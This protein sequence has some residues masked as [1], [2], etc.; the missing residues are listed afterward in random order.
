MPHLDRPALQHTNST[1]NK[2]NKGKK[3]LQ[4]PPVPVHAL[5]PRAKFSPSQPTK[6]TALDTS[7]IAFTAAPFVESDTYKPGVSEPA[8][9]RKPSQK[10]LAKR[11]KESKEKE[12]AEGQHAN[13]IDGVWHCS[14]CGCPDSIAIGR[15]KGPLG[16]KTMCGE[17]G[18]C[19]LLLFALSFIN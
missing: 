12:Y 15:R 16:D 8:I 1:P 14:N 9:D 2:P 17:C 6:S 3:I 13:F 19:R 5:R 18:M 4:A 11:V 10:V 7:H